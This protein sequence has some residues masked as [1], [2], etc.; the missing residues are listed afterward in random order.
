MLSSEPR[1]NRPLE[2]WRGPVSQRWRSAPFQ[3]VNIA[4]HF[5]VST[6]TRQSESYSTAHHFGN[7]T[8]TPACVS[9]RSPGTFGTSRSLGP[10]AEA[11]VTA[12]SPAP[13]WIPTNAIEAVLVPRFLT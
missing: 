10:E 1:K 4:L 9:A 8:F 2:D 12:C 13:S 5:D 7:H 11:P 3:E 6:R